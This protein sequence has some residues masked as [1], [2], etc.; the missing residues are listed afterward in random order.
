MISRLRNLPED[1]QKLL[2]LAACLGAEFILQELALISNRPLHSVAQDLQI[3]VQWGLIVS[4]SEP[5]TDVG[6]KLYAFGHDRIQ[7]ASYALIPDHQ[8]AQTHALIGRILLRQLS[9]KMRDEQL[10]LVVNQLNLGLSQIETLSDQ[11]ELA[12]LNLVVGK[13]AKQST[14]YDVAIDYFTIALNL[15]GDDAWLKNY[16]LALILHQEIA[17]S[18]YV[19][20]RFEAMELYINIILQKSTSLLD[21]IPAYELQVQSYLA[22]SYLD[23]AVQTSIS[24]ARLL[25]V[26]LSSKANPWQNYFGNLKMRWLLKGKMPHRLEH[27]PN[28][29]TPKVE[30]AVR[31]L[32]SANSAAYVG[33]PLLLSPVLSK[34]VE[35]LIRYGNLSLSAFVYAWYGMF[36]CGRLIQIDLGYK[37]GKLALKM[38]RNKEDANIQPKTIFIV[39]CMISH[40]KHHVC[41]TLDPLLNAYQEGKEGGDVEYS[42]WAILVRCEHL[43]LMGDSLPNLEQEL[44]RS[45]TIIRQANQDSA[46][47]HNQIFHQTVLNLLG[48]SS[49]PHHLFGKKFDESILSTLQS[50]GTEQTG[51]FHGYLCQLVLSFLF[52]QKTEALYHA[53]M[54]SRYQDSAAGLF[55]IAT[56][57]LYDSLAR[58][59]Q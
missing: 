10:F 39:N 12:Q 41:E 49:I 52:G 18:Y 51:I 29:K 34:Q 7:Q 50:Q 47:L 35:L 27:L 11:L 25:G 1:N 36:L 4:L 44:H 26:K 53:Q 21:K 2:S 37:F 33:H 40:W 55:A 19:R 8:K 17:V 15:I 3:A 31:I 46:L 13:R 38:L 28:I 24:V 59:R 20:G 56:F 14:A 54:A 57:Y 23:K 5:D 32:S 9:D 42:S 45:E 58:L 6:D 48:K 22:R 30:A 16:S 43:F